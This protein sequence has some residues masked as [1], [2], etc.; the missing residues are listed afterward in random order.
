[1][2][3]EDSWVKRRIEKAKNEVVSEWIP[4]LGV[5]L[6]AS[7]VFQTGKEYGPV[8]NFTS[9]DWIAVS[10]DAAV[11]ALIGVILFV[12]LPNSLRRRRARKASAEVDSVQQYPTRQYAVVMFVFALIAVVGGA[13]K[14]DQTT[15]PFDSR[16]WHELDNS[17]CLKATD[18]GAQ[19][20]LLQ[21]TIEYSTERVISGQSIKKLVWT[22]EIDCLSRIGTYR[23]V[24]FYDNLGASVSTGSTFEW[25]LQK[26]LQGKLDSLAKTQCDI[27]NGQ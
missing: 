16:C 25:S 27:E 24:D 8:G 22:G 21:Q 9:T 20:T 1:M 5:F 3:V 15:S 14:S 13:M 4:I 11:S 12:A 19:R 26:D 7:S 17:V 2:A 10:I 6:T 23:R 18:L